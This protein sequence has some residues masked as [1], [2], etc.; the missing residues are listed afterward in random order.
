M[1]HETSGG[2]G[3]DTT[4]VI[5]VAGAK[6]TGN[7]LTPNIRA[8][9]VPTSRVPRLG[10]RVQRWDARSHGCDRIT[11]PVGVCGHEGVEVI[12]A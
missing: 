8:N 1:T 3:P 6:V 2:Y 4:P 11:E 7:S 12:P 9:V 5:A 10:R